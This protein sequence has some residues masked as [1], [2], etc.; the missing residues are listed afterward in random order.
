MNLQIRRGSDAKNSKGMIYSSSNIIR[1]EEYV[2]VST[3]GRVTPVTAWYITTVVLP[4][5]EYV[6]TQYAKTTFSMQTITT[7]PVLSIINSSISPH[8]IVKYEEE[9]KYLR[10]K[11]KVEEWRRFML[12]NPPPEPES[13]ASIE[14][15][16]Y[17]DEEYARRKLGVLS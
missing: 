11:K 5:L 1:V 14:G 6:V 9:E 4:R 3:K 13:I 10:L 16:D 8:N 7:L 15:W 12:E 2:I 17:Y